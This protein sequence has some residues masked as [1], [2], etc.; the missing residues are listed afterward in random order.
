[1]SKRDRIC[2]YGVVEEIAVETPGE[3]FLSIVK[4]NVFVDVYILTA[5]VP[6]YTF[7][8][9]HLYQYLELIASLF[10]YWE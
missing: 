5:F 6:F 2:R 4:S 7:Y 1:M 8:I 3:L 9:L 10:S